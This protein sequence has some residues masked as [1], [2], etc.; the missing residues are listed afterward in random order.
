M[1]KGTKIA[2]NVSDNFLVSKVQN[3][4]KCSSITFAIFSELNILVKN[5]ENTFIII[6]A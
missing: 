3:F 5:F 4:K 6:I 1:Y 2:N